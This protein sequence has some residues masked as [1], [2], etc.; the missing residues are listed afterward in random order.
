MEP[1]K[2]IDTF[3]LK[4]SVS[5]LYIEEVIRHDSFDMHMRHF[6][7]SLELYILL[8]G[9]RFYFVEQNTYHIRD[10]MAILIAKNQIH[11]TSIAGK[12]PFHRRLLIQYDEKPFIDILRNIG[13][14]NADV[15]R[16]KYCS[17]TEFSNNKWDDLLSVIMNIRKTANET[18]EFSESKLI[19]LATELLIAVMDNVN[20]R[21]IENWKSTDIS[22]T[23]QTGVYPK[24]HEIALYLQE[25]CSEE[26]SLQLLS[27]R[28]YISKTYL[29]N[30]F[31]S[32]TGFTVAEYIVFLRI[33]KASH[34]L[35]DTQMSVTQ[36]AEKSGFGNITY[37]ERVFK[38]SI[39][40]TPL[41]YR[42]SIHS[43]DL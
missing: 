22:L 23:V 32:I 34:L 16:D 20:E 41:Q 11:K 19:I 2:K 13:C 27:K 26:L 37:F 30:S 31:K 4:K 39:R 29:T 33:R 14:G 25:N 38:E 18:S 7:N 10:K 12:N 1:E 8:E 40:K 24:I 42:K 35:A 43:E 28:F 5:G 36:V 6:H 15:F 17:I 9:D 3:V 21:L